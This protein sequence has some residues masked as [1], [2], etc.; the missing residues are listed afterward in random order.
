[1]G[2]LSLRPSQ[3]LDLDEDPPIPEKRRSWPI[4][5]VVLRPGMTSE[6]TERGLP[7]GIGARSESGA[8][9][10]DAVVLVRTGQRCLLGDVQRP[11]LRFVIFRWV[12]A[13]AYNAPPGNVGAEAGHDLS[14]QPSAVG[15]VRIGEVDVRLDFGGDV[16]VGHDES[17]WNGVHDA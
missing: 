13:C 6:Q 8:G 12:P 7:T 16:A 1:M 4:W 9:E 10:I 2:A 11:G 5:R 17:R 14:H 3:I 15:I